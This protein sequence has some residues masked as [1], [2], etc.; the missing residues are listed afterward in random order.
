MDRDVILLLARDSFSSTDT[1]ED[2]NLRTINSTNSDS[3]SI[4]VFHP[5]TLAHLTV[6]LRLLPHTFT[7]SETNMPL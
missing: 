1:T 4:V 3:A 2:V 7:Q 6:P 5:F